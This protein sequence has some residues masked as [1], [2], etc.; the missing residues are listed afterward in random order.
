MVWASTGEGASLKMSMFCVCICE[1]AG[2]NKQLWNVAIM[3]HYI[4][5]SHNIWTQF[6]G[7]SID[8]IKHFHHDK[9][10]Q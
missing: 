6:I 1:N 9:T 8:L 10:S 2:V 5:S 3:K 4:G 7:G